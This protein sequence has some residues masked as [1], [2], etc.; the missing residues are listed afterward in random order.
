MTKLDFFYYS[1]SY[2]AIENKI[3]I[4]SIC[5]RMHVKVVNLW[6]KVVTF[7]FSIENNII[8]SKLCDIDIIYSKQWCYLFYFFKIKYIYILKVRY[9]YFW[10]T[11]Y[12]WS[13]S[14]Y[15]RY[16]CPY[17]TPKWWSIRR[18]KRKK[19]IIKSTINQLSNQQLI[20]YQINN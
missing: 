20:N 14:V 7:K 2:H 11:K 16:V 15:I 8:Y 10:N 9:R 12:R 17:I 13:F 4:G 18:Y 1:S 19:S 3:V 5:I 6:K